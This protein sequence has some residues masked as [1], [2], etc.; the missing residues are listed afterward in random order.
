MALN[1]TKI[2]VQFAAHLKIARKIAASIEHAFK[3]DVSTYNPRL[4]TA[5]NG[6][7]TSVTVEKTAY[8]AEVKFFDDV[9]A[10]ALRDV[11]RQYRGQVESPDD[12]FGVVA[13]GLALG[14]KDI[15]EGS[16]G[17]EYDQTL[18]DGTILLANRVGVLGNLHKDMLAQGQYVDPCTMT[19]GSF[20]AI[21]GNRGLL[22]A[23]TMTYLS[24]MPTGTLIF[25]CVD[26]TV[27]VCRFALRHEAPLDNPLPDGEDLIEAVNAITAEKSFEDYT[28]GLTGVLLT[29]P[30]LT[31]PTKAGD[32]AGPL[33]TAAGTFTTPKESDM[34]TGVLQ[35]RVTRQATVGQEWLIEFFSDST[36]LIKVGALVTG[37]VVG[38]Y[39]LDNVMRNGTRFQQTFDRAAAHVDLP[40][41]G[42]FRDVTFDIKT[43][44][45]GDKWTRAITNSEDFTYCTKIGKMW[46]W[47]PPTTGSS[48]WTDANAASVSQT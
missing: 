8:G 27:D 44:R 9:L 38:S 45:V 11:W 46:R 42:N 39:A 19:P 18:T 24:Q 48:K 40:T 20:T 31:A 21:S 3:S 43:P 36:K 1:Y 5:A 4:L 15:A 22:S 25:E 32:A 29:R 7:D 13:N 37:T 34:R 14:D 35:V 33:F 17:Y 10:L 26:E 47:T 23:I 41:A 2:Q 28:V 6:Y 16:I 30:G 12:F